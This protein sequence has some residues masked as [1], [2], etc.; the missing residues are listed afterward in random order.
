[1]RK[2]LIV[3]AV[4]LFIACGSENK[5]SE[6]KEIKK[7]SIVTEEPEGYKSAHQRDK[8]EFQRDSTEK[9][10]TERVRFKKK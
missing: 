1:M 8:E 10:K 2:Y 4:L 7:D 3:C 6:N 5:Q 9:H